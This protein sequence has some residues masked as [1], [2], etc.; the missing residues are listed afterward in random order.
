[1]VE[2]KKVV[3]RLAKKADYPTIVAAHEAIYQDEYGFDQTFVSFV[4][5]SLHEASEDDY[6]WLATDEHEDFLGSI[7]VYRVDEQ[8]AQLR[9]FLVRPSG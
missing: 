1:M 4:E 5:R 3:I 8:N 6:I 7:A 2:D 9:F